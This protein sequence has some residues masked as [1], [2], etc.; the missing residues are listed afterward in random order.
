MSKALFENLISTKR[1]SHAYFLEGGNETFALWLAS[2]IL[3]G[4]HED[5][6]ITCKRIYNHNH[7][8]VI[9]IRPEGLDVKVDQIRE[10]HEKAAYKSA[11]GKGQVFIIHGADKMNIQASNAFLKFLEEPKPNVTI[12]LLGHSKELLLETIRSRVQIEKLEDSSGFM[13]TAVSRGLMFNGLGIFEEIH[14][15]VDQAEE[16]KDV[17]DKWIHSIRD[18]LGS[19]RLHAL[20]KVQ[21]LEKDFENREKRNIC[22]R[23][24][25]SYVKALFAEAKGQYHLWGNVPKYQWHELLKWGKAIDELSRNMYS[26]GH[27]TLQM[28]H[29]IKRVL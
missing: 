4:A 5:D 24:V 27:F 9:V 8:D 6:C 2:R 1:L 10:I 7:P 18:I 22:L 11:D 19:S 14:I 15:S 23:L 13:K 25:Q 17:A 12:L 26:N 20:Q 28:E 21:F 3:C 16:L 29:F